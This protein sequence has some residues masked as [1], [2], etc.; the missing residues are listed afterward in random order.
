MPGCTAGDFCVL[1]HGLGTGPLGQGLLQSC[2]GVL[3]F[4]PTSQGLSVPIGMSGGA[5]R[6]SLPLGT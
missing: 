4:R 3:S 2:R 6:C 1:T 5:D